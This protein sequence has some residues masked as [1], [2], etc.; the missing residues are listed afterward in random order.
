MG[1]HLVDQLGLYWDNRWDSL[2]EMMENLLVG[3]MDGELAVL[4]VYLSVGQTDGL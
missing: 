3:P 2:D 1:D 4:T